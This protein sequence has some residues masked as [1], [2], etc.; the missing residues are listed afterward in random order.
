V[1]RAVSGRGAYANLALPA[2]LRRRRVVGRE[3]A[4]ATE[5]TYGT[6]RGRGTYDA[7]LAT[8]VDRPLDALD[9][10]VLDLLRLGT[11]QLLATR[12]PDHA[13]V[14]TT[15]ALTR[16]ELGPGPARL[17]NAVLRR[18]A[19]DD[20]DGWLDRL[21]PPDVAD[22]DV[23]LAVRTSH[24][25]WVVR[26]LREALRADGRSDTQLPDLLTADNEPAQVTLAVRPGRGSV[27]AVHDE[28]AALGMGTTRGRW[29]PWAVRLTHGDPG[30]LPSV[31]AGRAGVQDE[32]S[33]LVAGI[34]ASAP[35]SGS[36]TRWVDLA[37]GPGGKA[38][39]LAGLGGCQ[40]H[41]GA[42]QAD[43]P[44]TLTAVEINPGRAR[45]V[46]ETLTGSPVPWEVV[47]A[48]A[49]TV[50]A[51]V[52][53]GRVAPYDRVLL[54]APCTGLGALRRRPEARWRRQPAD[55][56]ALSAQQRG[57]LRAAVDATRPGGL[58]AYTT[59]SP[60]LAET[61]T[62]VDELL[63][64]RGDLALVDAV[65]VLAR[66]A[67]DLPVGPG[68]FVQLWPD[69]HGTDAMFLALLRRSAS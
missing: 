16:Q 23:A 2:E 30:R 34:L 22:P 62:V 37:A 9:P 26:A 56:A 24:P 61:R 33:Q 40:C 49:R 4:W 15:V 36:D 64:E 14:S 18:V 35:L 46:R 21:V 6:L 25:V 60:H 43:S 63:A 48:D 57:L 58:I 59:C 11:H 47:V 31:Q 38:A 19:R 3:A 32:G 5:L 52:A 10:P 28:A 45:L 66:L 69:L 29:S 55:V 41:R 42:S 53:A 7:I 17:V 13:A 67:P 39:L 44:V 1:L 65:P 54:D 12:V 51:D 20:L 50:A 8:C 68:P 27:D